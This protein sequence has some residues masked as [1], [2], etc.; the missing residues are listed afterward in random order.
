MAALSGSIAGSFQEIERLVRGA[1]L[2]VRGKARGA[3]GGNAAP[4]NAA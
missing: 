2:G 4:A 1:F 3:S